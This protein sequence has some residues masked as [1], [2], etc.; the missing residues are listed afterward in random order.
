MNISDQYPPYPRPKVVLPPNSPGFSAIKTPEEQMMAGGFRSPDVPGMGQPFM[1]TVGDYNRDLN[2][3]LRG[4]Q[5]RKPA[6]RPPTF[7][8]S[9]ALASVGPPP[10]RPP[11][12]ERPEPQGNL[13]A[14]VLA[15]AS[16]VFA[17]AGG[18][19]GTALPQ[20]QALE[21]QQADV[22]YQDDLRKAAAQFD[23]DMQGWNFQL[24]KLG[25]E[26]AQADRAQRSFEADR[27]YDVSMDDRMAAD[28]ERLLARERMDKMDT[29]DDAR[30]Q[31][32][33][34]RLDEA[35]RIAAEERAKNEEFRKLYQIPGIQQGL[36]TAKAKE[37]READIHAVQL[38]ILQHQGKQAIGAGPSPG[39]QLLF[40]EAASMPDQ[41]ALEEWRQQKITEA[42]QS[43]LDD[44]A[45]AK[46]M[47]EIDAAYAQRG[48]ATTV[49][50]PPPLPT[51]TARTPAQHEADLRAEL[52]MLFANPAIP[53]E[54]KMELAEANVTQFINSGMV[55][56]NP[57]VKHADLMNFARALGS[58]PQ[59]R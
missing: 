34:R 59:R 29:R 9:A 55:P 47:Q 46:R 22:K 18:R 23:S 25:M 12:P 38:P 7:D 19:Q 15:G 32:T 58:M 49:N 17:A 42:G 44:A 2:A 57:G 54:R 4:F 26:Q 10:V 45:K 56:M 20:M 37:K 33:Q 14:N 21:R 39:Q 11:L 5:R 50:T 43:G 40:R 8:V 24:S 36:E 16:D 41:A 30:Y 35:L 1:P 48:A 28:L 31:D 27:A 3:A 6:P 51:R 52:E 13:L 53:L